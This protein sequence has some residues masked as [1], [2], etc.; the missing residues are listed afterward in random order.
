MRWLTRSTRK[1]RR[2]PKIQ[3][4]SG[5]KSLSIGPSEIRRVPTGVNATMETR[6]I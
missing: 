3:S 4:K 1:P 6:R 5:N 2:S